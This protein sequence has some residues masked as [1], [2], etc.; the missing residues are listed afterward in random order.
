MFLPRNG[1][2]ILVTLVSFWHF[3][4]YRQQP[5]TPSTAFTSILG[6]VQLHQIAFKLNKRDLLQSFPR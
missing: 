2:P 6:I 5:L 3:A 4:V 1:A